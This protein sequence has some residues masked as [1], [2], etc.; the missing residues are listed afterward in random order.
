MPQ[1][2]DELRQSRRVKLAR[3]RERGVD[4]FPPRFRRSHSTAGAINLF[5]EEEPS[6]AVCS[7]AGRITRIRGMGKASFIDI[8]DSTGRLQLFCRK[9]ALGNGYSLL[10]DID[11]GDFVGAAGAMIKTKAGEVSVEVSELTL[12]AKALRPP[13]EKF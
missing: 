6:K 2:G 12:L 1:R 4:P 10:E 5:S 9:D 7:V 8:D 11:L 3:L 13:P